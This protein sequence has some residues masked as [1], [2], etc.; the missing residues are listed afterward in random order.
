MTKTRIHYLITSKIQYAG[1]RVLRLL[2]RSF[3]VFPVK[4]NRIVCIAY[5]GHQYSCNPK[6]IAE[7]LLENY[8]NRFEIIFVL[9]GRR[10]DAVDPRVKT[11]RFLTPAHFYYLYT[12][13]VLIV[14]G[15]SESYLAK[16]NEQYLINT[17]HGGGAYKRCEQ[18]SVMKLSRE[19]ELYGRYMGKITDLMLS[20]S[21]FFTKHVVPDLFYQVPVRTM[22]CGMPRND[23]F[24]AQNGSMYREKVCAELGIGTEHRIILYAPTFRGHIQTPSTALTNAGIDAKQVCCAVSE[25]FKGPVAFVF[26]SHFAVSQGMSAQSGITFFDATEYPDMQELLVAVDILITDYSSSMWDFSLAKKP[27]FLYVPD[28]DD[29]LNHDRGVYTPVET[30]PGILCRTNEELQ[31]AILGFDEGNYLKK[32][33]KHH[34]NLGSCETGTARE[35]VCRHIAGICGVNK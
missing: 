18:S 5:A 9:R 25:R 11:V 14:N 32:V 35:Q 7:Y 13:K 10:T 19:E 20:S 8:P 21:S 31:N 4:R 24:F 6:Y 15:G 23:I 22:P 27:C 26:R 2:G 1:I 34:A 12:A 28:L 17:W 16:R 30:W 29:Y 33:E 3:R